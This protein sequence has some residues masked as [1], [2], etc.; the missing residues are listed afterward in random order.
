MTT[1][2]PTTD[3]TAVGEPGVETMTGRISTADLGFTLMHEHIVAI[4]DGVT[5]QFPKVWDEQAV[6]DEAEDALIELRNRG[7][8]TILDATV[9]GIGRGIPLLLPLVKRS[10]VQVL[11]ATGIYAFNELPTY[12]QARSVEE[13][14]GLFVG[15][16]EDGVQGTDVKAAVLKCATDAPGVTSGVEK[17]LRAVAQAHLRTGVPITTHTHA[18]TQRGLD[19]QRIFA[20]EG[21]NLGRVIIGHSG[22]SD[23]LD[24]L[25]KLLDAGS[26]IGMDRFGLEFFLPDERRVATVVKLCQ[27]GYAER[28]VLS[29]DAGLYLDVP[30][31][32]ALRRAAPNWNY[33]HIS[34]HVIPQLLEAGV[35]QTQIDMMTRDN[36]RRIFENVG[37][38]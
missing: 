28:M 7:V 34:E 37:A 38:Y 4:S 27:M 36:A 2:A 9:F 31:L 5:H 29:H 3:K 33:C 26:Y 14:A 1:M 19:Q 35:S 15:D 8:D 10:G 17:V 23:D 30:N 16:I 21:V 32:E 6:L 22:D 11:V 20:E 25:T 13:M 24:Y 12:F 18:G